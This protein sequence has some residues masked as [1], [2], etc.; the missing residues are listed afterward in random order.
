MTHLRIRCGSS[1]ASFPAI[2]LHRRT[3][4]VLHRRQLLCFRDQDVQDPTLQLT[5]F[6]EQWNLGS[7]VRRDS[8]DWAGPEKVFFGFYWFLLRSTEYLMPEQSFKYSV[9]VRTT[10]TPY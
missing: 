8:L 1:L 3:E 7:M 2:K 5:G 9:E 10:S 4:N 6:P